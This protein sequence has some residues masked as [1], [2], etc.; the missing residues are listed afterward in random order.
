MRTRKGNRGS[1]RT[2]SMITAPPKV[3]VDQ[4]DIGGQLGILTQDDNV[5]IGFPGEDQTYLLVASKGTNLPQTL[6]RLIVTETLNLAKQTG[7]TLKEEQVAAKVSKSITSA[8]L[9]QD[10]LPTA[11][12]T[13]MGTT[14]SNKIVIR[15][16]S[17]WARALVSQQNA[18]A[19]SQIKETRDQFEQG[20]TGRV[21]KFY[22]KNVTTCFPMTVNAITQKQQTQDEKQTSTPPQR[23]GT[24]RNGAPVNPLQALL[25]TVVTGIQMLAQ[26]P[27]M[28]ATAI[29]ALT[30]T[31]D[32]TTD[33][34]DDDRLG[35][36]RSRT[37]RRRDSRKRAAELAGTN[38]TTS[39]PR[40]PAMA[41]N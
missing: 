15:F 25:G 4:T 28:V 18:I 31:T 40:T 12:L 24:P 17:R 30:G 32:V 2:L 22:L 33:T 38:G 19:A 34:R 27:Q 7:V 35:R 6:T 9:N 13:Q 36:N 20:L 10:K 5:I 39:T 8:G 1:R 23:P 3:K 11:G 16:V 14:K 29:N 21:A 37:Q 26:N 41:R